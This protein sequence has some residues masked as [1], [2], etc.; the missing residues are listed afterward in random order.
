MPFGASRRTEKR[1]FIFEEGELTLASVKAAKG[2]DCPIVF[3]LGADS[4]PTD[5]AGRASFYVAA[6][7]AKM[8]LFVTGMNRANTL[9]SEAEA[10]A[11]L[12]SRLS[13]RVL[14]LVV[15]SAG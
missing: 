2:Y 13:P 10:L 1:E 15:P 4:F 11:V 7:R 5:V 6:T 9:A 14:G 8:H 12:L 3:L